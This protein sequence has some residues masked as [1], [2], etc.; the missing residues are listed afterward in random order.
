MQSTSGN[1]VD[2]EAFKK[3]SEHFA[4]A[5]MS[6]FLMNLFQA[7]N[8]ELLRMD[9]ISPTLFKDTV[10]LLCSDNMSGFRYSEIAK[11]FWWTGRKLLKGR[12]I[13]FVKGYKCMGILLNEETK[14]GYYDPRHCNFAVPEYKMIIAFAPGQLVFQQSLRQL[15]LEYLPKCSP[16]K[17]LA[18]LSGTVKQLHLGLDLKELER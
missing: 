18:S 3:A 14:H 12:F 16:Q 7:V 15:V 1:D 6:D 5:G 4:K 11:Q 8:E 17:H 13:R 10:S 2:I 9:N